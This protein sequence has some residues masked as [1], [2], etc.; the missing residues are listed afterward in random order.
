ME[1]LTKIKSLNFSLSSS[2]SLPSSPGRI[3]AVSPLTSDGGPT[4]SLQI[5][6]CD[7]SGLCSE[8]IPINIHVSQQCQPGW[9]GVPKRIEYLPGS[10]ATALAPKAFLDTCGRLVCNSSSLTT[11][12][13]LQTD[14]IGFGCDRETYSTQSQR[15]LCSKFEKFLS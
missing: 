14:H 9:K 4:Y 8:T 13:T 1:Y 2:S 6:S 12:V 11:T 3:S 15:T 5:K 7:C 10:K